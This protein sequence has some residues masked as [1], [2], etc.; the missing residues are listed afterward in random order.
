MTQTQ[1]KSRSIVP[2]WLALSVALAAFLYNLNDLFKTKA[3]FGLTD[4]KFDYLESHTVATFELVM[5]AAAP[6]IMLAPILFITMIFWRGTT[7]VTV[8]R[9]VLIAWSLVVS[10]AISAHQ[11]AQQLSSQL[12]GG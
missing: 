1:Y 4:Y 8:R 9:S 6:W 7:S 5:V 12:L 3:G 2:F 10:V 11:Q